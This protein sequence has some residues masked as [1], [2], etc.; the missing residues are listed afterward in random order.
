MTWSIVAR[1]PATGHIG[2]AVTTCAF[3]VGARC[4]SCGPAS[5][6]S[7]RRPLSIPF[8][9]C[10][11]WSCSRRAPA[12][13]TCC[14]CHGFRRGPRRPAGHV[15]DRE[16]RIAPGRAIPACPG[17]GIWCAI[18]SRSPATCWRGRGDRGDGARLCGGSAMPFARRMI[19]ALQAAQA[20][21]GDKR[22][23]QSAAI[24]IHDEEEYPLVDIRVDDHAEPLDELARLEAVSRQRYIHYR[25]CMPSRANPSGIVG[26][27]RDRAVDR[28]IHGRGCGI[29]FAFGGPW[30]ALIAGRAGR[31]TAMPPGRRT[32]RSILKVGAAAL[33]IAAST[34]VASA[35]TNLRIGLAEDRTRSTRQ[36]RGPMLA[37]SS[38][39]RSA[40]SSSTSTTSSMSCRSSRSR[41][42]QLPTESRSRSSSGPA[43]SSMTA[44]PSMRRPPSSASSVT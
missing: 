34:I 25:K 21:G 43:S 18:I 42:R 8:T 13:M 6:R 33:M 35:Q 15:M 44:R 39:R 5:A 17:A 26:R 4:P 37:A 41:R 38:S 9:G 10:G 11:V 40:T 3:A 36:R 1:D 7:P 32:M 28:A 20:A 22:G 16:G 30:P 31:T 12:P 2:V 14:A 23:K 19:A 27:E 24:L 29:G